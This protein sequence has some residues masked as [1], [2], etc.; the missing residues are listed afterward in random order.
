MPTPGLFMQRRAF[1]AKVPGV[2]LLLPLVSLAFPRSRRTA[3]APPRH[4]A[5]APPRYP[6][7]GHSIFTATAMAGSTSG[8]NASTAS[9]GPTADP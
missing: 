8:A 7:S 6:S 9:L 2:W 4:R 5:T 3:G 1:F